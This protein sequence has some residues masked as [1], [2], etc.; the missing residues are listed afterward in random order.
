MAEASRKP[1][2]P[3]KQ[4]NRRP[5]YI[6]RR[7]SPEEEAKAPTTRLQEFLGVMGGSTI[8]VGESV[9]LVRLDSFGKK[10]HL[11]NTS[12]RKFLRRLRVP[13]IEDLDGHSYFNLS[14]LET[15]LYALLRPGSPGT[16]LIN[17]QRVDAENLVDIV[18]S[19]NFHIEKALVSLAYVKGS[20][21]EVEQRIR[22]LGAK[23]ARSLEPKEPKREPVDDD[24]GDEVPIVS[25][26]LKPDEVGGKLSGRIP[27]PSAYRAVQ[28]VR[29]RTRMR[30]QQRERKKRK[31]S[32]KEKPD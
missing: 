17:A 21:A 2:K 31:T 22:V 28:K 26:T 24:D 7:L 29:H 12:A 30:E 20:K 11:P 3:R 25:K 32:K 10:W 6:R 5:S 27:V 1:R 13:L 8:F 19:L 16:S 9:R 14:S 18:R 4:P 15:V 23:L